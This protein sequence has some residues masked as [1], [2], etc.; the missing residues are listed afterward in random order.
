MNK[1]Q[2]SLNDFLNDQGSKNDAFVQAERCLE[3]F[4]KIE[5]KPMTTNA[6][7]VNDFRERTHPQGAGVRSG[8]F[9]R[10]VWGDFRHG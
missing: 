2:K 5:G 8:V 3:R 7:Q 4:Q 6:N 9:T 1:G 10:G